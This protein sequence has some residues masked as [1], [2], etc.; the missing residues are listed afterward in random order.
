MNAM[1]KGMSNSSTVIAMKKDN[2]QRRNEDRRYAEQG[3]KY[4]KGLF[5]HCLLLNEQLVLECGATLMLRHFSNEAPSD[6]LDRARLRQSFFEIENLRG[7]GIACLI[8]FQQR[9]KITINIRRRSF[10]QEIKIVFQH[11]KH[12]HRRMQIMIMI[13]MPD[14]KI[15]VAAQ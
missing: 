13:A 6:E 14:F 12:F 3:K 7:H 2:V 10:R 1:K 4:L 11:R 8:I 5:H 15:A 9:V